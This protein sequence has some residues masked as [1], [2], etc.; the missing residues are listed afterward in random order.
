MT[1]PRPRWNIAVL[2]LAAFALGGFLA[3]APMLAAIR[4]HF[5]QVATP[6]Q[7]ETEQRNA[8][9]KD[10]AAAMPG[11]VPASGPAEDAWGRLKRFTAE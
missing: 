1:P 4:Q 3:R 8:A 5:F 9:R 10:D 6:H 11:A 7:G 2:A